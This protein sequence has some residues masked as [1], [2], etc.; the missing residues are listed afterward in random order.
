MPHSPLI[1]FELCVNDSAAAKA[2]YSSVLGWEI[3][4]TSMPHYQMIATGQAPEGGLMQRT[5]EMPPPRMNVYFYVDDVADTLDKAV[6]AGGRVVLPPMAIPNVG[7]AGMFL[8][9]EGI[10]VGVFHPL[11]G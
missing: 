9:P 6:A 5:P 7:T 10:A 4:P 3:A 11:V 2:F 8:D 1:H